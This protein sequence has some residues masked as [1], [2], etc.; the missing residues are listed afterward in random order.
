MNCHGSRR[1]R[2]AGGIMVVVLGGGGFLKGVARL[3][4]VG[5]D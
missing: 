1:V 3:F 4:R 5:E 2:R